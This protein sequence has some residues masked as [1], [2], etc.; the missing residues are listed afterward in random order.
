MASPIAEEFR[1]IQTIDNWH[2][3]LFPF[4]NDIEG[5]ALEFIQLDWSPYSGSGAM[6]DRIA[7]E[8]FYSYNGASYEIDYSLMRYSPPI[9]KDAGK[10][11]SAIREIYNEKGPKSRPFVEVEICKRLTYLIYSGNI[12]K[13]ANTVE[14]AWPVGMEGKEDFKKK[15]RSSIEGSPYWEDLKIINNIDEWPGETVK[16]E[17]LA[18]EF[19]AESLKATRQRIAVNHDSKKTVPL[20]PKQA[21]YEKSLVE[22]SLEQ[23]KSFIGDTNHP[24]EVSSPDGNTLLLIDEDNN[25][26]IKDEQSK[27]SRVIQQHKDGSWGSMGAVWGTPDRGVFYVNDGEFAISVT[28][29]SPG[30]QTTVWDAKRWEDITQYLWPNDFCD[31][32]YIKISPDGRYAVI[33]GDG[34]KF[35]DCLSLIDF[36]KREY[37]LLNGMKW[38]EAVKSVDR[39]EGTDIASYNGGKF[40]FGFTP[41]SKQLVL[42]RSSTLFCLYDI[43]TKNISYSKFPENLITDTRY[44]NGRPDDP[45]Y[46]IDNPDFGEDPYIASIKIFQKAMKE[47]RLD[48]VAKYFY[49]PITRGER[50]IYSVAEFVEHF[51]EIFPEDYRR[52]IAEEEEIS[53]MGSRGYMLGYGYEWFSIDGASIISN[54]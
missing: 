31:D 40:R 41:D 25:I 53:K 1:H 45:D 48:I 54:Y 14:L 34:G 38:L 28:T 30:G 19:S 44:L 5:T 47:E 42:E 20:I 32:G 12:L 18:F 46:D 49:F 9:E 39:I 36:D 2:G 52:M 51:D 43:I 15:Y 23:L 17:N 29:E 22:Y 27:T 10:W 11:S 6:S 37:R 50:R 35:G 4:A 8:I 3:D 16:Q 26:V 21:S 33:A 24:Q 13:I 7:A